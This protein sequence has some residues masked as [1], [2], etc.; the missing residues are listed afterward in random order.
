M[1]SPATNGRWPGV[2]LYRDAFL[3]DADPAVLQEPPG[4]LLVHVDGAARSIDEI[5]LIAEPDARDRTAAM[6]RLAQPVADARAVAVD[7]AAVTRAWTDRQPLWSTLRDLGVVPAVWPEPAGPIG[8]ATDRLSAI[9]VKAVTADPAD[10]CTI[11]WW[12]C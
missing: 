9:P 1:S 2:L 3:V 7:R 8:P 12:L 6:V 11:F 4:D 5:L 10:W